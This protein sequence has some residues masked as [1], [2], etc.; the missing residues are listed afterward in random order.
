MRCTQDTH[1]DPE[2]PGARPRHARGHHR[3]A[4]RGPSGACALSAGVTGVFGACVSPAG[5]TGLSG[6]CVPPTGVTGA[7]GQLPGPAGGMPGAAAH[8]YGGVR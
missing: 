3:A 1:R 7:F 5:V 6:A 8:G 4:G 2:P